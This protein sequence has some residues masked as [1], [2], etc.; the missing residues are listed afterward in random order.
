M[1]C[2]EESQNEECRPVWTVS[3]AEESEIDKLCVRYE[4]LMM[5]NI[6]SQ[7]IYCID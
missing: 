3:I 7:E 4:V 5:L 2:S 1:Q 6:Q